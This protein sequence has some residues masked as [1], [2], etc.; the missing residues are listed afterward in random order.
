MKTTKTDFNKLKKRAASLG[1]EIDWSPVNQGW[2]IVIAPP[3]AMRKVVAVKN[4]LDE[5]S[6]Y[7]D[8]QDI[9]ITSA[10]DTLGPEVD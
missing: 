4:T 10:W 8:D 2:F 6:S 9:S 1:Y 7:L 3:G 5:V